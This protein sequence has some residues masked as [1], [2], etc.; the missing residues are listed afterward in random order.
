MSE[1]RWTNPS[2]GRTWW[3]ELTGG[4]RADVA[5][6]GRSGPVLHFRSQT[7]EHAIACPDAKP[8]H[9]FDDEELQRWLQQAIEE[10]AQP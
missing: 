6:A 2:D 8:V 3:I 10:E 9:R 1:R 4:G 5:A 7:E